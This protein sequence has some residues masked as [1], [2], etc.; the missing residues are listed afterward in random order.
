MWHLLP[1]N[2]NNKEAKVLHHKVVL[3]LS[4]TTHGAIEQALNA[5]LVPA[6]G[7]RR[8]RM[9]ALGSFQV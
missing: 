1:F 7:G 4:A 3:F 6:R 2:I 5:R 8:V 9:C